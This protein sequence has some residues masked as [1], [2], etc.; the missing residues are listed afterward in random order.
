MPDTRRSVS[1]FPVP[2]RR[3]AI[4]ALRGPHAHAGVVP[5]HQLLVEQAAAAL[6]WSTFAV[7]NA[8]ELAWSL[9]VNR[10][11]AVAVVGST[12]APPDPELIERVRAATRAPVLVLGAFSA[13]RIIDLLTAG[14]DTVAAPAIRPAELGGRLL[15]L[16]RRAAGGSDSGA[17]YLAAGPLRI[18]LWQHEATLD[19][20]PLAL[21]ATEFKLLVCLMEADGRSVPSDRIVARVWGWAGDDAGPNLLRINVM[22]LRRKLG[23]RATDARLVLSVRGTGYRFG[24]QVTELGERED[25]PPADASSDLLLAQRLARRCEELA[26]APDAAQAAQ[27]VIESLITEGTVDAAGLHLLRDDRLQLVAHRGFSAA[28]E[29]A[30]R[31]LQLV[32]SGYGAVRALGSTEPLQLRPAR[33]PRFPGTAQLTRAELPGTYLFVPLRSGD[34]VVGAMGLHRHSDE[35]FGPLTITYLRAVGALCGVCLEPRP[36]SRAVQQR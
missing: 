1:V 33:A 6:D 17:R 35:P 18:D 16:V 26:S 21:T 36:L 20:Q 14:A 5:T 29:D 31:E 24:A 10:P 12:A 32:D 15:A 8:A 28:W 25:R 34:A 13:N 22:R 4:V 9:T 30:A 2:D 27:R 23:E 11:A 19:Q 7:S 3:L